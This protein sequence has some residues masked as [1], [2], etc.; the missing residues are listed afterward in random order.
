MILKT[1]T[2]FIFSILM[3][4]FLYGD[5]SIFLSNQDNKTFSTKEFQDEHFQKVWKKIR[6]KLVKGSQLYEKQKDVPENTIL[7]G[8]DKKDIQEDIDEVIN[9]IIDILLDDDFLEY[10]DDIANINEKIEAKNKKII[11]YQEERVSAPLKS[12]FHTTKKGY[13]KKIKNINDE[14]TILKHKIILIQQHLQS[15]FLE[16]GVKLDKTQIEALLYRIDSSD[17]IQ[18]SLVMDILKKINTQISFL[19]KDTNENLMH[20]K[21]YYGMHL[22]SLSLI[23]KIQQ[24]Y[25]TKVREVYIPKID[26]IIKEIKEVSDRTKLRIRQESN[27]N[28]KEIY[29]SNLKAQQLT[30]KVASLYRSQLLEAQIK[31]QKAQSTTRANLLVAENTYN[32]VSLSSGLYKI[33]SETQLMFDEISKIQMPDIIPFENIQIENKYKELTKK[34]LEE[35]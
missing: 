31:M 12:L 17:I 21:R 1:K 11:Q 8:K 10:K 23:L 9:N 28:R 30:N 34:I 13:D 20:A 22:L 4:S 18:V 29:K 16:I 25:I 32:T 26:K 19:M 27:N 15:N 2:I 24:Q 7:F 3:I 33:V 5:T 6:K 35:E 14:L